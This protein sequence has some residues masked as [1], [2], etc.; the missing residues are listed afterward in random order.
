MT[1]QT[2]AQLELIYRDE[3]NVA[4][5]LDLLRTMKKTI[6]RVSEK[7]QLFIDTFIEGMGGTV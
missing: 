7:I 5:I 4:Y 6:E 2:E 3:I 1:T